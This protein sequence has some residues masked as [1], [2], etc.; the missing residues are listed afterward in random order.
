MSTYTQLTIEERYY[1]YRTNKRGDSIQK[2]AKEMNRSPS[3]ISRE[4]KRNTGSKGYR[5]KQAHSKAKQRHQDKSKAVKLTSATIR[6]IEEKYHRNWSPQQISGRMKLEQTSSLNRETIYRFIAKDKEAGGS[7]YKP[8]AVSEMNNRPRQCLGYK[9]PLEVF[10][11]KT[12]KRKNL[13]PSVALM[14]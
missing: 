14:R 7:L 11:E 6:Y 4:L 5:Y 3:T 12:Q 10:F 1:V 8:P 9:T 2:I 13:N